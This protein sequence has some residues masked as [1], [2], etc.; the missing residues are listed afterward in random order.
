MTELAGYAWKV[1]ARIERREHPSSPT[2]KGK[3]E[4]AVR[5]IVTARDDPSAITAIFKRG[6]GDNSAKDQYW[7]V[8]LRSILAVEKLAVAY[9][10]GGRK[11]DDRDDLPF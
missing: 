10:E 8:R 9:V 6:L 3:I 5:I 7:R 2:A 1:R 11:P 4:E